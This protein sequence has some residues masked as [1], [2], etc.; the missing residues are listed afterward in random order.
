MEELL[1]FQFPDEN[2]M[3][4]FLKIVYQWYDKVIPKKNAIL[5]KS[6]PNAGKN[7]FFDAVVHYCC[8]FGQVGNF[9]KHSSF[10]LQEAVDKRILMWNEP[11]VETSAFEEL[12]CLFGGDALNSKVK[13]IV[14]QYLINKRLFLFGTQNE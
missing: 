12:K 7:F 9:D 11:Q 10:P 13:Y 1:K 2:E 5:I 6:E 14:D 4:E 3:I 8:N